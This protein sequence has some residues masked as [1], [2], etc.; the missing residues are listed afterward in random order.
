MH[1][2]LALLIMLGSFVVL[3]SIHRSLGLTGACECSPGCTQCAQKTSL[4][5]LSLAVGMLCCACAG[6]LSN[7]AFPPPQPPD[8][9]WPVPLHAHHVL[10]WCVVLHCW[11]H[12]HPPLHHHSPAD[13]LGGNLPHC[14]FLVGGFGVD[15]LLHCTV[16][17]AEL[18]QEGE[19][20]LACYACCASVTQ[21]LCFKSLP[22]LLTCL[23]WFQS[24]LPPL[25]GWPV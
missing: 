20:T 8:D 17:G 23:L 2:R 15:H 6:S 14:D 12:N 19:L 4:V 18:Q 16:P 11:R 13:H 7:C 3:P 10:L 21:L 25:A 1:T 24:L 9:P 5:T 22:A